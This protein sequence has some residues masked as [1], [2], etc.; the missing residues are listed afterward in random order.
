MSACMFMCVCVCVHFKTEL[1]LKFYPQQTLQL[2]FWLCFN[3]G[4]QTTNLTFH[5]DE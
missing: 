4:D 1:Q 5:W 3:V 2:K